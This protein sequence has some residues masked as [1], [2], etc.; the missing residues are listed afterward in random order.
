MVG[1]GDPAGSL[2]TLKVL[3][4]V[5]AHRAAQS[6]ARTMADLFIF[7]PFSPA[8]GRCNDIKIIKNRFFNR[9]FLIGQ[10]CALN[11]LPEPY[12]PTFNVPRFAQ[13][14]SIDAFFLVIESTDP[15]Y[16]P[17]RTRDFLAS[18]KPREVFD[19]PS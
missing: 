12:H 1:V 10:Q 3:G 16:D 6:S 7:P 5:A 14:G 8:A 2:R 15:L 13:R 9:F 4:P 19:V 18:L 17:T 11:G